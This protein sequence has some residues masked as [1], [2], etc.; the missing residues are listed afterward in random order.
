MDAESRQEL[1]TLVSDLVSGKP[2]NELYGVT[3][4]H[5]GSALVGDALLDAL[6]EHGYSLEAFDAVG[7]LT[8]ASVPL[9]SAVMEAAA[10][11]GTELDGFVMDFV[12]PSIK[13]PSI[14]RKRVVLIDAWLSEKSYVQTS[15]LVTL[16]NGNE[17]SLDFSVVEHEGAE[18]VAITSLVGGLGK[19]FD[20]SS[21]T[22]TAVD[23]SA[24]STAGLA[25]GAADD[26]MKLGSSPVA[27]KDTRRISV[28][29]PVDDSRAEVPFVSVFDEDEFD[30]VVSGEADGRSLK[31]DAGSAD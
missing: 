31:T 19:S 11:R 21:T 23:A 25:V 16:R 1:K 30:T 26:G 3:F 20:P 24:D 6:T 29:N 27:A 10:R 28:I 22:G 5:R 2:F 15:S 12:Y 9:V 14:Q 18:V 8:A 13:G 7:A 4:D 17:L